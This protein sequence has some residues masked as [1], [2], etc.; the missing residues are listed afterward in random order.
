KKTAERLIVDLKGKI[1]RGGVGREPA[2]QPTDD[3]AAAALQAL[4]YTP[5]ETLAALRGGPPAGT[6]TTE[7]RVTEALRG[8]VSRR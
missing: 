6:A 4:G 8:A 1:Q 5:A 2:D 3:D 7:E